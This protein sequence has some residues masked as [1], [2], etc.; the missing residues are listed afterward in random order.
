MFKKIVLTFA[1]LALFLVVV[2][3][4]W[5]QY[6]TRYNQI[7]VWQANW[8][9]ETPPEQR[10]TTVFEH[11]GRD[12]DQ[13]VIVEYSAEAVEELR[14]RNTWHSAGVPGAVQA[15]V[16]SFQS[17][18]KELH[19]QE[20]QVLEEQFRNHP[21]PSHERLLYLTRTKEDGS[22]MLAVLDAENRRL[23]VMEVFF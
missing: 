9:L 11:V 14:E 10:T 5:L 8:A 22:R 23:Y 15:H 4:V 1:G 16:A 3:V 19:S 18:M 21:V 12:P 20:A 2:F 7:E 6:G 17:L 13:Y